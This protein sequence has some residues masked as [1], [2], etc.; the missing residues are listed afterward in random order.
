MKSTA[1][2]YMWWPYLSKQIEEAVKKCT[3]CTVNRRNAI[4]A[5]IMEAESSGVWNK[6]AVDIC[7][8][9]DVLDG[10]TL[11][12]VMDYKSHFPFAFVI[13]RADSRAVIQ[14]LVQL[15][16][17]FG[18]PKSIVSDNGRQFVSNEFEAFLRFNGIQHLKSA[19]YFPASNGRVERLH[20]TVKTRIQRIRHGSPEV[21]FATALHRTLY[22]IRSTVCE[23]TG[24][25]PFQEIG[26]ASCRERV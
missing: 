25:T 16:S 6:I 18:L 7:G 20:A 23:S 24:V 26:R 8:P 14:C 15:F 9:S 11:F 19:N 22:D 13:N 2:T 3:P 21:S 4:R 1:R 17:I 10:N 12:T 5:P